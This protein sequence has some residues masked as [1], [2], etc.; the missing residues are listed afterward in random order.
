MEIISEFFTVPFLS[1]R[2]S[3]LQIDIE[4]ITKKRKKER[5][6]EIFDGLTFHLASLLL[7]SNR[8]YVKKL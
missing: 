4:A 6:N 2:S 5:K 8:L 1:D 3:K 7:F